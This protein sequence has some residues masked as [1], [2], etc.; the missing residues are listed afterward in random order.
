MSGRL[1]LDGIYNKNGQI[2]VLDT[3]NYTVQNVEIKLKNSGPTVVKNDGT[4]SVLEQSGGAVILTADRV[5]DINQNLSIGSSSDSNIFV[6]YAFANGSY[7]DIKHPASAG[8]SYSYIRFLHNNSVIGEIAQNG[9][10]AV[11]YI[12]TSDYRLKENI[13]EL[14]NGILRLQNLKPV[15]FNFITDPDKE[16]D[17]FLAHEVFNVVPEAITGKKDAVDRFGNIIPQG[18]D[19]SKLVPLL[20]AALLEAIDK[21]EVLENTVD[22]LL[23]RI[24]LIEDANA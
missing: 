1:Y 13:T 2:K 5:G 4:T 21:I 8:D 3:E 16:V 23:K 17:G 12:E 22:D 19:K 18:I 6:N 24:E 10:A 14:S 9:T 7:I 20:T 15:R 11:S